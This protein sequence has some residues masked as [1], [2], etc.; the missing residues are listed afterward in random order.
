MAEFGEN[1]KNIMIMA[2]IHYKREYRQKNRKGQ[3]IIMEDKKAEV[4]VEIIG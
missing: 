4:K 1:I 2:D 3:E